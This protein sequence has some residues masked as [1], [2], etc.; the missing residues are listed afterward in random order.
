M[1]REKEG[2]MRQS[3]TR[4]QVLEEALQ[5]IA[6]RAEVGAP[7]LKPE[8]WSLRRDERMMLIARRALEWK[9]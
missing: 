3:K 9:P 2:W 6:L 7:G 1:D 8:E 4:E 5:E